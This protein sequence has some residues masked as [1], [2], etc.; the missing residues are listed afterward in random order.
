[1]ASEDDRITTGH[2]AELNNTWSEISQFL[3]QT[4]VA[5]FPAIPEGAG[6]I[7]Y[8]P[9]HDWQGFLDLARRVDT[10]II[11]AQRSTFDEAEYEELVGDDEDDGDSDPEV[12]VTRNELR[13]RIGSTF[14]LGLAF[15][16]DGVLHE[17]QMV[18]EWWSIV[19]PEA[20][21][22]E[23][24]ESRYSASERIAGEL[25]MRS[26]R[27]GW[28]KA[29]AEDRH[30]R[31]LTSGSERHRFV[32]S[33]LSDQEIDNQSNDATMAM[34]LRRLEFA[35]VHAADDTFKTL[36]QPRLEAEAIENLGELYDELCRSNPTWLS[37]TVK[38]RETIG[39][40]FMRE[41]YGIPMT[42]VADMLARYKPPTQA[43]P[44]SEAP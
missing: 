16:V 18:A 35:L 1:M 40:R 17:W 2:S 31:E 37:S 44:L 14:R 10:Q 34:A 6:A 27:E 3:S 9:E 4:D 30:Y 32:R 11:Y 38:M 39:R 8:W 42:L 15:S 41:R 20:S 7:A 12:E 19:E 24:F 36:V 23:P 26:E 33:F 43:L 25:E 21:H 29:I 28:A 22:A 5:V 13:G